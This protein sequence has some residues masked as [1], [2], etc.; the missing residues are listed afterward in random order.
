MGERGGGGALIDKRGQARRAAIKPCE[1]DA[2]KICAGAASG[3]GQII[4]CVMQAKKGVGW[5]CSQAI[6][7]AGYR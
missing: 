5:R 1:P 7:D 6:T 2:H 4:E 3:D